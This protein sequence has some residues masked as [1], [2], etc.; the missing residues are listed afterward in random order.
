MDYNQFRGRPRGD[1]GFKKLSDALSSADLGLILDFVP[2]QW[3]SRRPMPGGRTSCAGGRTAISRRT[4]DIS[5]EAEKILVPTLG[6]PYGEA[7]KD[8]DLS[9]VYNEERRE[10]R[11]SAGGYEKPLDPR[12]L[13]H[14]FAFV[15][16]A[17]RDR[18]VRR[19]S[20]AVPADGEEL[21]E[22]FAEHVTDP[23]FLAELKRGVEAINADRNALH[24]LHEAQAWRLA[25]WRLAREKL[26][27][28]RFFE[29]ADLIG[30]RQGCRRVF[31]ESH[32]TILRLARERRLDGIRIDHVDGVADPKNYPRRPRRAF[33]AIG[34][35]VTIHVE[36]ILTG[37]ERLR[38][39]WNIAGT[40]G[41]EFITAL[42]G[43]Y[44]DASQEEAMTKAYAD[45]V[46][47]EEDLRQ[48]IVEQKRLIFSHN[49]AGELAFLTDEALAVAA[50]ISTPATSAGTR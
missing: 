44:V 21:N 3:V 6:K 22:R 42:S 12:T 39:S 28:R 5:W 26:S 15:D 32:R 46:G 43:L 31:R 24:T 13:S 7:L 40:T 14:V 19:F 29:I 50:R 38:R 41:Y 8:G 9:V 10:L 47:S 4:F 11:F 1:T 2:N 36:K 30:V 49:L 25:W 23:T 17:E 16:H 33:E 34:R 37:P 27:Y 35:D 45:F 48:M 20:A 18:M